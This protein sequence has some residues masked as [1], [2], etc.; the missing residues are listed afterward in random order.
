MQ[1]NNDMALLQEYASGNSEAAFETL[2]SR[3]LAFVYS[4]ALRQTRDP[5]FAEEVTQAVFSILAQ[6]AGKISDKTILTGWLFKT[7]RFVA[8]AQTRALAKRRQR[9]QEMQMQTELQQT[10]LDAAWDLMSP[11]LDEALIQLGEKDRQA[12]VL[13]F[14]Q[15]KSF[16]EVGSCL[17]TS[18]DT[19]RKR[20]N[21]A[22][23]K[24]RLYFVKRGIA[25]TTAII[26]AA[27]SANSVQAAPVLLAKSVTTVAV[28]KG[29]AASASTS[30]L[31][32]GALKIMAWTKAKTAIVIGAAA[33]LATGTV[34]ITK[35][36]YTGEPHYK[37]RSLSKWLLQ[38]QALD[39]ASPTT[40]GSELDTRVAMRNEANDALRHFGKR[41]VP[42]LVKWA[43]STNIVVEG[44]SSLPEC[45]LARIG[46]SVLGS[47]AKP[48][49]PALTALLTN[50]NDILR[51][52]ALVDLS[53]IG[54]NAAG[55]L[56]AV[57]DRLENDPTPFIRHWAVGIVG[58]I[59][60]NQSD[61]ILPILIG[62]L[63]ATN[64]HTMHANSLRSLAKLGEQAK[65]AVPFIVPFL[66][67]KDLALRQAATNALRRIDRNTALAAGVQ[68]RPRRGP[69][70]Q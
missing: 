36:L 44:S 49:V 14:F 12:V 30:T 10:S 34:T 31:I 25:S 51:G 57:I 23:E 4:A 26:A 19:A 22:L 39:E 68:P 65:D 63:D 1:A 52:T 47:E 38:I 43:G 13:H 50:Q 27:I 17:G 55:A 58:D 41:A 7:T 48:A 3:H 42:T 61:Q 18:Q 33:L 21:R 20:T 15:K 67:N 53:A 2:V 37:G 70:A 16:A 24:L 46:F 5:N 59:G 54:T 8:I 9:E 60:A 56:S 29:T 11:L 66:N 62:G 64:D 28:A 35:S 69:R 45:S 40:L 32:K 6:K